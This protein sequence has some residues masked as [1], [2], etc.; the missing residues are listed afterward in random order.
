MEEVVFTMEHENED[1]SKQTVLER[2]VKKPY[3]NMFLDPVT[4]G[5]ISAKYDCIAYKLEGENELIEIYFQDLTDKSFEGFCIF[6]VYDAY[7]NAC[8]TVFFYAKEIID[9]GPLT[10]AK[11]WTKRHKRS[12]RKK[13]NKMD[14]NEK[15][16]YLWVKNLINNSEGFP[17]NLSQSEK[18]KLFK[19]IA[20]LCEK[21]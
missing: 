10:H 19:L 12:Y 13:S 21:D 14:S 6:R 18:I 3:G 17:H 4:F 11:L 15:S 16:R 1:F 8:K 5:Q 7:C 9:N 2:I 20:D